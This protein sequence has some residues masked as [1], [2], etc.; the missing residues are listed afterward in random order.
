[1]YGETSSVCGDLLGRAAPH[2][3]PG[4]LALAFGEPVGQ[5][6]ERRDL[7]RRRGLDDHG[8]APA[9]PAG[10][11][12]AV[13]QQP[14]PAA[15][16]HPGRGRPGRAG[17][18]HGRASRARAATACTIFGLGRDGG[19][20]LLDHLGDPAARRPG[21][22]DS[23]A[24]SLVEET[25]PGPRR[26][27][28]VGDH[29]GGEQR[30][31]DPAAIG[32]TSR[33]EEAHL[34]LG[35]PGLCPPRAAIR[36]RPSRCRRRRRSRAAR[37]RCRRP[38]CERCRALRVRSPWVARLV[39]PASRPLR[40]RNHHLLTSSITYSCSASHVPEQPMFWFRLPVNSTVPG[41]TVCQHY[42]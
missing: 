9:V 20:R 29:G 4:D 24:P 26:R 42:G 30:A 41:S 15:G 19:W 13:E 39:A 33:R 2:A 6:D 12:R 17:R 1:M 36:R 7:V 23:A 3:Q 34:G 14:L 5:R 18:R 27:R 11:R 25:T 16:P 8:H 22:I 21:E 37:R 40:A 28:L 10:Q 38:S 31:P 35:E 32:S